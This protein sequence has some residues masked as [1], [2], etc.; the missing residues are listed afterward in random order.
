[1][2]IAQYIEPL[3]STNVIFVFANTIGEKMFLLAVFIYIIFIANRN[4][5]FI[6]SF[7]PFLRI[8]SEF[9]IFKWH[10]MFSYQFGE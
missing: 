5:Y 8:I 2:N 7:L 10:S 6:N 1:M 9:P 4:E 3:I